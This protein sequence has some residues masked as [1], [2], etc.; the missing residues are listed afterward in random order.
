MQYILNE[1]NKS[2]NHSSLAGKMTIAFKESL[3]NL[4]LLLATRLNIFAL[5]TRLVCRCLVC[6]VL[7]G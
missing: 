2:T 7:D 6:L 5:Y 1:G 4:S 3:W